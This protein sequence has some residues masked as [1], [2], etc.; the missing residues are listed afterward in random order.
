M[1]FAK[2]LKN[3][4]GIKYIGYYIA[5]VGLVVSLIFSFFVYP[6]ISSPYQATLDPDS[7]GPLGY[8]IW[9]LGSLS[10]YPDTQP[11]VGRGP[12][13]PLFEA[14]CLMV[15]NGWWPKSVQFGQCILFA[16]TCFLVFWIS[17]TLW[18][19]KV[20]VLTSLICAFHLFVFWYTSRIFTET[21]A[22]F[23]FTLLIA[24]I[25]YLT[26]KPSNTRSIILGLVLGIIA[27]CK[28]TFLPYILFIPSFLAIIKSKKIERRFIVYVFVTAV[29]VILP[30]TIRNWTLTKKIIPIHVRGGSNLF[31]G[32]LMVE[33]YTKLPFS[34]TALFREANIARAYTIQTIPEHLERFEKEILLDSKLLKQSVDR[35]KRTP[36]FIFKK[37][38][39]NA[40]M[41]WTLGQTNQRSTIISLMQIPLLILFILAT[42][43]IIKQKNTLTVQGGNILFVWLYFILHL[44]FVAFARYGVVLIPTM[45]A[46]LGVLAPIL[47]EKEEANY[48]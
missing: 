40:L 39:F 5:M 14:F 45:L 4:S 2:L 11:T 21:L 12:L 29:I 42:I 17:K 46:S 36:I 48:N 31:L 26:L 37:I 9:K 20:A 28:Q 32:D 1:L 7:H 44:P 41:F 27:L 23:L 6:K 24:S 35:Y 3:V 13:Y 22:I 18:S 43:R 47:Y 33:N 16:I 34:G 25:L 15:S 38:I 8:G 30:W 19:N 10:Y